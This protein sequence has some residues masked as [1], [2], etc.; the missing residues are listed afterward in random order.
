MKKDFN[1]RE[2]TSRGFIRTKEKDFSDDGNRF[3]TL[4]YKGLEITYLKDNDEYYLDI[5]VPYSDKYLW[6]DISDKEWY[7]ATGRYNG[8]TN[9]DVEDFINICEETLKGI[10]EA[11]NQEEVELDLTP[12]VYQKKEE[13]TLIDKVIKDFKDSEIIYTTKFDRYSTTNYKVM[14]L[15]DDYHYL[16]DTKKSLEELDFNKLSYTQKRR[17]LLNLKQYGYIKIKEDDYKIKNIY[18]AIKG[19]E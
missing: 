2:L 16:L 15:L 11:S 7:R 18:E 19:E 1:L 5:H 4:E 3:K 8:V 17:Y 14:R 6:E 12:L 9:I 13:I 10:E